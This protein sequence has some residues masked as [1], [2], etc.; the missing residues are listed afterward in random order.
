MRKKSDVIVGMTTFNN[1]ML[2]ISVPALGKLRQK[3]TLIIY[4]DNPSTT[5]SRRQI[6][7]M[8]YC[9]DLHI[10]NCVQNIGIM[11]ARM[12]IIRAANEIASA[13]WI[14]FCNDDDMLTDVE[15]PNVAPDNFA[16]IR[17]A[18]IIRHRVCDLVRAIENTT[19]IDVDGENVEIMRPNLGLAG[20]PVR[21]GV[22]NGM[23]RVAEQV[24]DAILKIDDGLEY[25]PP[26]D[27][28]M[29]AFV[30]VYARHQNPNAVPIYMDQTGYIK[31][32]VDSARMKY[33]RLAR[34]MRNADEQ[35]RRA[36]AKYTD[37]FTAALDAAALRGTKN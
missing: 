12:E 34:P 11:R 26:V 25:L 6:R 24:M 20:N 32:A 8:G 30:N 15:I 5:V 3:F 33:G 29:W 23:R 37:V 18:M 35:Y 19:D 31:N 16:I 2:R 22:L 17:N 36:I 10:I 9:G 4:N 7:R 14:V 21:M 28:V 1:E 27:T 13:Q